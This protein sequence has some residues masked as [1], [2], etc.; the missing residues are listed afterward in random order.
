MNTKEKINLYI[1][2]WLK[3]GYKDDIPDECPKELENRLKVPSYR[4]IAKALLSNDMN[5]HSIGFSPKKSK[6]YDYYKKIELSKRN[7]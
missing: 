3:C 7:G 4:L 1:G 2:K 5:L 6:Y